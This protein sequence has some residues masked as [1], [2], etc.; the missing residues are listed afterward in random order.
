[1]L[2]VIPMKMGIQK[3]VARVNQLDSLVKPG[4]DNLLFYL[5]CIKD[6]TSALDAWLV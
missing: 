4:N 6:K 5:P 2:S 3:L 1:M